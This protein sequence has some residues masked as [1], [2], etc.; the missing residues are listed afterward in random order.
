MQAICKDIVAAKRYVVNEHML[1]TD[2]VDVVL[3]GTFAGCRVEAATILWP[4]YQISLHVLFQG[5][6]VKGI[7]CAPVV[8]RSGHTS[9]LLYNDVCIA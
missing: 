7:S 1:V 6:L 3:E 9:R 4:K 5:Q 2:E 8:P